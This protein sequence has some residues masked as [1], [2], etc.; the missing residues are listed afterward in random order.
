MFKGVLKLRKLSTRD[1]CFMAMLVAITV[2]LSAV[3]GFLRIGNMSKFNVSFISVYV[4]AALFGP[5][6]GGTIG[7]LAD[8]VSWFI[9]PTGPF[10]PVFTAIEFING[11][12]FGLFLYHTPGA[13]KTFAITAVSVVLCVV[14]QYGVNVIRTYFLA[15]MYMGGKFYAAF[16]SRI[17][18]T[19][20]MAVVKVVAVMAFEPLIDRFQKVIFKIES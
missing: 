8:F 13:K 5:I 18:S 3:S 16:I 20:I 14:L 7:A 17:P 6:A 2:G 4:G 19:T 10:V 12:L 15:H 9:N 1:L 11:F